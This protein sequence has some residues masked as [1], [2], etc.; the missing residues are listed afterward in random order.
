M[1]FAIVRECENV[2]TV[3]I[4]SFIISAEKPRSHDI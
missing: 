4:V 2:M 3:K 1:K